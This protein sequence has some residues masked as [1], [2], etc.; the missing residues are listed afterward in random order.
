MAG[1]KGKSGGPRPNAGGK[2]PGAGRKP[3]AKAEPQSANQPAV[4]RPPNPENPAPRDPLEFLLAV[5][6]G[7]R[8]ATLLQVRSAI[9][10]AQYKHTKRHDGGKRDE[11]TDKAKK[12]AGGRFGPRPPP[13]KLIGGG[14]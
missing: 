6:T 7:E 4:E 13:L 1:V 14:S 9:A 8:M 2:R 10:V 11:A 12:A 3:K 5:M